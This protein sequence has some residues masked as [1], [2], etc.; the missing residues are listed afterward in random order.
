MYQNESSL[1]R[2]KLDEMNVGIEVERVEGMLVYLKG[3][4]YPHKGLPTP[5][6]ILAIGVVKTLILEVLK[7]PLLVFTPLNKLLISFNKIAWKIMG[8]FILKREN[9]TRAT[10]TVRDIT[11]LFLT[12]VGIEMEI[13][14]K[15][16]DI[17]SH[18]FEY[19]SAYRFR[20]QDL[21]NETDT[22][23]I[24]TYP[25]KEIVRLI[26]IN[27]RRDYT[28]GENPGEY[29]SVLVSDKFRK[30]ASLIKII[31]LIPKYKRAFN[32]SLSVVG[33]EGLQMDENDRYW[34]N[35]KKDYNY[36]GK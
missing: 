28:Y 17:F 32:E 22:K 30:V 4:P 7:N 2:L 19:D 9:Q 10:Q 5:E 18:I 36:F 35:L 16:A 3:H 26:E 6:V 15:T 29:V 12:R 21:A 14:C 34:A 11:A 27:R 1:E 13:A 31:L 20:L 25:Q 23:T 24:T 33:I 8:Q